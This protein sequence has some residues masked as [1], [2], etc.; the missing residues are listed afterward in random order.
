MAPDVGQW[1]FGLTVLRG[2][3]FEGG[4]PET[5]GLDEEGMLVTVPL[6]LHEV[7]LDLTHV[8]LEARY[9]F[10]EHWDA[11]VRGSWEEKVQRASITFPNP[12]NPVQRRAIERNQEIHH[13]SETYRGLTD[14][15]LLT[16]RRGS[17]LL[18]HDD[19]FSI[20][21]G[22]SIPTGK[23]EE[24]PYLLGDQGRRHLHI[25]F[26]TGT[27]DPLLELDYRLPLGASWAVGGFA[28]ARSPLYENSRGFRGAPEI[29]VSVGPRFRIGESVQLRAEA[30]FFH[31]GYGEW[32]GIRDPNTG[33]QSWTATLG[34]GIRYRGAV[35]EGILRAPI[36]QETLGEGDAFEQGMIFSLSISLEGPTR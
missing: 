30:G 14:L 18:R 2:E 7:S 23:T 19:R 11:V 33:L 15:M 5:R 21:V 35:V 29:T 4:H 6:H 8:E 27:V 24:N 26:G 1:Q 3:G 9:T 31:Q 25:Q 34:L 17:G 28:A 22:T 36:S 10:A 12:V 13:R 32:D 20:A 16:K